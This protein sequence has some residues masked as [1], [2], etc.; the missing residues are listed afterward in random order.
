[1]TPPDPERTHQLLAEGAALRRLARSLLGADA[2]ADDLVQDTFVA[3]LQSPG[4]DAGRRPW[5]RGTL[6]N[7]AAMWRR[8]TSRRAAREVVAA[9]AA[10]PIDDDPAAIAAQVEAIREV[11]A[12]VHELEEPFRTVVVL[13][14]WRGLLPEAIATQLGVPRNTVRSRLQ[15]GLERLRA[16][17]DR[18]FGDRRGWQVALLPFAAAMPHA[19]HV[20]LTTAGAAT[21]TK[22]LGVLF[23]TKIHVA[24]ATTALVA[25]GLLLWWLDRS[26]AAP[27]PPDASA[28]REVA[29][30]PAATSEVAAPA[31]TTTTTA[32]GT[33]TALAERTAAAPTTGLTVLGN[34]TKAGAPC[35]DF[36]LLLQWFD[37]TETTGSP[38]ATHEVRSDAA[39]QFVWRGPAPTTTGMLLAVRAG[40]TAGAKVWC[41]PQLVLAGQREVELPVTVLVLDRTLFGRVHDVHGAPIAGAEVT[42]NGWSD[43][44]TF[45]DADGRYEL[46]VTGPP[47]PLLVQK[48]GYRERV[49]DAYAVDGLQRNE[50]DIELLPGAAFRGRVVDEAGHAI[51]GAKVNSM[52]LARGTETDAA[53]QFVFGG[54]APD[55]N[56]GI[57][58]TKPGFQPTT[59]VASPGGEPLH[60]VLRPGLTLTVRVVGD[61]G[62]ALAGVRVGVRSESFRPMQNRGT[63]D[64]EGRVRIPDLPAKTVEILANKDGFVAAR[65][66][67]DVPAQRSELVLVLRPGRTIAGRVLDPKD[68]PIVGASVYCRTTAT[69]GEPET[70]GSRATSDVEGRFTI[71]ELPLEPC[72]IHA[73][74]ADFRRASSPAVAGSPTELVVRME[75]AASVAGRVVDGRTGAPITA[76]TITLAAD[77][78][79]HPLQYVDPVRFANAD[80]SFRLAHWQL[81]PGVPLF[82][83]VAA[84]GYPP[85]RL[86][87]APQVDAKHDQHVIRLDAGTTLRGVV[88]HAVTGAPVRDVEV[89][90]QSGDPEDTSRRAY[91]TASQEGPN[92]TVAFTDAEGRFE[93]PCVPPGENRLLLT[94]RDYPKR[95]FGPFE[96]QAGVP[97]LEVQPTLSPGATLR[98]RV[99]GLAQVAGRK[100]AVSAFG[101]KRI[102]CVLGD[103]GSFEAR[104]IA[105]GKVSLS[106]APTEGTWHM[107]EID[108]GDDD[109]SGIEFAVPPP[110]TGSIRATVVG[111]PRGRGAVSRLGVAK[112]EYT[113]VRTFG[114]A[115]ANFAVEGLSPGRYEVEVFSPDVGG[116]GRA[117]VDVGTGA[118]AV[119]IDVVR[120]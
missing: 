53:G 96:V 103:D 20:A 73:H 94:H 75:P 110:G 85:Q 63:T 65:S 54:A 24:L 112:G 11:A 48:T 21:A 29:A 37:G 16:R 40:P 69:E 36:V 83:E 88:R 97:V 33:E 18:H 59:T 25:V 109:V 9:A 42:V 115:D 67:V 101:D 7:L 89:V 98:G 58:V 92:K 6:H 45:S 4:A 28:R 41:T 31:A 117:E 82:V 26:A 116:S 47:Y 30:A 120:R 114:Y 107:M 3:A 72:T 106:F 14:F 57:T 76:F 70:V 39:G 34:V 50:L 43:V 100:L 19:P 15:R 90:V 52:G 5:L 1:M 95:T 77:H 81:Q 27:P 99:T 23:M 91:V 46:K 80:G 55:Q 71:R 66:E 113:T 93:L 13:R 118:V 44:A 38:A 8:T 119:T 62:E 74:H 68:Q 104:G 17:L 78:E 60:I 61:R 79:V 32:A 64:A 108:V 105:A 84:A 22:A 49:F 86:A 10:P 87:S 35:A 2:D 111:L 51:A 56:H 12:A 102:E